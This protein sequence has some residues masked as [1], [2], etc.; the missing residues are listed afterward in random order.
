M[1]TQCPGQAAASGSAQEWGSWSAAQGQ[2]AEPKEQHWHNDDGKAWAASAGGA[3][4]G[5]WAGTGHDKFAQVPQHAA[6]PPGDANDALPKQATSSGHAE[7]DPAPG[8]KVEAAPV[9]QAAAAWEG[10]PQPT[11][12]PPPPTTP[13][14]GTGAT[15]GPLQAAAAANK[16]VWEVPPPPP[17]AKE[18]PAS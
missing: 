14:A 17:A 18:E 1:A 2:T 9:A 13:P 11:R 10:P 12:V 6:P 15:P 7:P 8:A 3:A 16:D 4:A 5:S